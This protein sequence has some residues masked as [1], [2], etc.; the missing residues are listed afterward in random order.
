MAY[1]IF[2]LVY[3]NF[4]SLIFSLMV[5]LVYAGAILIF[6]GYVC[7]VCPNPIFLSPFS[8]SLILFSIFSIGIFLER[9]LRGQTVVGSPTT[10]SSLA[11]FFYSADGV[12]V[13]LLLVFMLLFVLFLVN[14]QHYTSKGPFRSV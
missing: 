9:F 10:S 8:L 4:V 11:D 12:S 1:V 5:V 6:I 7:A 3:G 13:L 14:S 2:F